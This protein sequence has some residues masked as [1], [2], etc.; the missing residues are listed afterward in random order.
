MLAGCKSPTGSRG[1]NS[2][3]FLVKG[4]IRVGTQRRAPRREREVR[5]AINA[6]E[7]SK[8]EKQLECQ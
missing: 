1:G 2:D 3:H 8:I 4:R 5:K 6:S 7:F